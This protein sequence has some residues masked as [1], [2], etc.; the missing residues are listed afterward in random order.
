MA[1]DGID[2][3]IRKIK[4]LGVGRL[5]RFAF[6]ALSGKFPRKQAALFQGKAIDLALSAQN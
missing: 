5:Y 6:Y 4:L 3:A 1:E 2:T